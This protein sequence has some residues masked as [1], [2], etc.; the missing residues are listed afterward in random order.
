MS[1]GLL[2]RR[3]NKRISS[4]QKEVK[5]T[6]HDLRASPLISTSYHPSTAVHLLAMFSIDL[7][8]CSFLP[9]HS[10]SVFQVTLL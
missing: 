1:A 5:S 2:L 9:L 10:L 7:L 3:R 6:S 4:Q 8:T